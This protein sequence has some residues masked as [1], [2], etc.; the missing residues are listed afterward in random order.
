MLLVYWNKVVHQHNYE[1]NWWQWDGNDWVYL[2]D[3]QLISKLI[4]ATG[5]SLTRSPGIQSNPSITE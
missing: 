4:S 2:S 3:S 5:C 1:G